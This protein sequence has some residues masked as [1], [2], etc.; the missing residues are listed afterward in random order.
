MSESKT[1]HRLSGRLSKQP[2]ST[3]GAGPS[4]GPGRPSPLLG[5]REDRTFLRRPGRLHVGGVVVFRDRP[6]DGRI[7]PALDPESTGTARPRASAP[8]SSGGRTTDGHGSSFPQPSGRNPHVLCG[9]STLH[10]EHGLCLLRYPVPARPPPSLPEAVWP[11]RLPGSH[12][13]ARPYGHSR[14]LLEEFLP[15]G[16]Q[17]LLPLVVLHLL[18]EEPRKS[19]RGENSGLGGPASALLDCSVRLLLGPGRDRQ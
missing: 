15:R 11:P 18:Y 4:H 16:G 10:R 2:E 13:S 12:G 9:L 5:A 3:C 17:H 6:P 14:L 8:L 7:P 1:G 19:A